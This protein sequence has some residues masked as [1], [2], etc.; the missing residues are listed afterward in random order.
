MTSA[1]YGDLRPLRHCG[2]THAPTSSADYRPSLLLSVAGSDSPASVPWAASSRVS[3]M[4][5]AAA[6]ASNAA[7]HG[8]AKHEARSRRKAWAR[9]CGRSGV[10]DEGPA[11]PAEATCRAHPTRR[12]VIVDAVAL[13]E[14][15]WR[16]GCRCS[17]AS[18]MAPFSGCRCMFRDNGFCQISCNDA[19]YAATSWA[20]LFSFTGL[21]RPLGCSV[22]PFHGARLERNG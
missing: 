16:C 1:G 19:K 10:G 13:R 14:V 17:V 22:P 9:A 20:P 2:H 11:E 7:C 12:R 6:A 4:Q 3:I 21:S 15:Q 8:S 5:T 18:P